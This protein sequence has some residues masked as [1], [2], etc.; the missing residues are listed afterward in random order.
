MSETNFS[1]ADAAQG[2]SL[3][4]RLV[5]S[6]L[7]R[8][9][10]LKNATLAGVAAVAAS[11]LQLRSASPAALDVAAAEA[12]P[13]HNPR[14]IFSPIGPST[15]DEI[16]LPAGYSYQVVAPYGFELANGQKV[17]Y[18]HD[19]LGFYPIDMVEKGIDPSYYFNGF[20][21]PQMSSEEGL[22]VVNHEYFNPM[23]VGGHVDPAVEKSAE[24]LQEEQHSVGL[25]VLHLRKN[26]EGQWEIVVDSPHTRRIDAT[27]TLLLTGPA[28]ELDGGP[29]AIGSLANCSG[30]VT[31]WGTALSCE[32]N[33]QDYPVALPDGYGWDPAVYGKKHYGWV[34]EVDPFDAS[35][36]PRKHTAMGRFRHENVAVAVGKD[37]SVVAYMGDDKADSCVYKFV[38]DKKLSGN[39]AEDM[40]ILESGKL[41]AADFGNGKWLLVDYDAQEALQQAKK[42]DDTPLFASQAEVLADARAAALALRATPVDRPED[43]E[44]HPKDGSIFVALTNNTGH[45]NFH[46]QIVRIVESEGDPTAESFDWSIF[47]VG[48]PQS[49]FSSPD[50]LVFDAEGNLWMVTDISSSR[51]NKGIFKFHGNNGL[52]FFRTEGPFAGIAYQFASGPVHCE[53]TG[54]AWTPDGKT[55]FLSIQHPGEE[56]PSLE[57]LSSH[58]PN[59]GTERPLPAAVAIAGFPG[60]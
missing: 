37:G 28:A 36:T 9:N 58:W 54:P 14:L 13:L 50:N 39:R 18:N 55:L 16:V 27:S 46:G 47:A 38:A 20:L 59:G 56:S 60:W 25:S 11:P 52:F 48:G 7:D 57:E 15:A 30:G 19:W 51:H 4:R 23:F 40:T 22:L 41:Y 53:M 35:S 2:Q 1:K 49:G 12:A 10:F 17:G 5:D 21:S 31:P 32:E 8:R 44:I 34:V 29:E 42:S 43:I 6:K 45:G 24:Q 3:W 26:G 33:F